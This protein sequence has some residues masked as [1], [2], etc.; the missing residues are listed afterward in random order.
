MHSMNRL[1]SHSMDIAFGAP[2][3]INHRMKLMG[4]TAVWSPATAIEAQLMVV[5]KIHAAFE[6]W[7]AMCSATFA[8]A[9]WPAPGSSA[10]WTAGGQRRM[11]QRALRAANRALKPLSRRVTANVKRLG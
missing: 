2:K 4:P 7:L 8:A 1:V 6:C 9:A 11:T 10:W 5:E 3:V